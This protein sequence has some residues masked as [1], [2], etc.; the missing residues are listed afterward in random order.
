MTAFSTLRTRLYNRCGIT[1]AS[2]A[3]ANLADEAL[4]A[5]FAKAAWEGAPELRQTYSGFTLGSLTTT[6]SSHTSANTYLVVASATGVYP[7]DIFQDTTNSRNF[8]IRTVNGTT[9]DFGVPLP[10]NINGNTVTIV[11]RSLP[12]PTAGTVI[13]VKQQGMREAL[14]LD[15]IVAAHA[16]AET[17]QARFYT[18]TFG[19]QSAV[20]LL[21]FY[22][23]P[24][25]ATQFFITQIRGFSEDDAIYASEALLNYILAEAQRYR[26]LMGAGAGGAEIMAREM[27]SL[28]SAGGGHG[29][30]TRPG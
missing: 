11:R 5:A 18:Q 27:T 17:G 12:L 16:Q 29:I 6:V 2:T 3:E 1:V 10:S 7:G 20:G 25:S 15:P 30:F 23:A 13:E 8:L 28:R 19:E 26:M 24:T 22:P 14:R 4:N 21:N 9:L